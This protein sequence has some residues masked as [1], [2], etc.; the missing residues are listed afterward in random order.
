MIPKNFNRVLLDN[1]RQ[2]AD[3]PAMMSKERQSYRAITYGSLAEI[4]QAIALSLMKMGFRRGERVAVYARNSPHW[5][6]ADLGSLLAGFIT[7]AIYASALPDEAAYI[8]NDLEASIIFAEGASQ[9]ETLLNVRKDI[10]SV[11][12]VFVFD[13]SIEIDDPWVR[14]F[15]SLFSNGSPD[16]VGLRQLAHIADVTEGESP[17]CIIYTSGTTGRPKGVVLT[18]NNYV[19]TI[20]SIQK[21]IGNTDRLKRNLS[22]LPLAHAFERFAGHYLVLYMGRCIAYVEDFETIMQNFAETKPNF[23]VAV[24][25]FF[26]S[27]HERIME[28]VRTASP[29]KKVL[30]QWALTVGYEASHCQQNRITWS[31]KLRLQHKLADFLV[32]RKVRQ[33]FG[34]EIEFFVSGGAPLG[35]ELSEFFHAMGIL[36]LEGWGATEATTPSTLNKPDEF[37]FGSVGKPLPQVQVR[38]G[39]DG[40]LEVKGPNVFKEYWHDSEETAATFTPDGFYRTGD[41]GIIDE[42]GWVTI[43]DRKKQLIITSGGKNI[44]PAPIEMRLS[45]SRHVDMAYVHGDGRSYLTALLVLSRPAVNETAEQ[46]RIVTRQWEELVHHPQIAETVRTELDIINAEL[47][48]YMQIKDFRLL[49]EPFSIESGEMTHTMKLKRKVI[50]EKY[51]TL[52]DSMYE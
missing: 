2:Y 49:A 22:F 5:A 43:I 16:D 37:Q 9:L 26:E 47:P 28:G 50:R 14:P 42:D 24:P 44:A 40:E 10:P 39:S 21:H 11:R 12:Q 33:A 20:E 25:R 30:F 31:P 6:Q 19:K 52:I 38:V 3:E 45:G 29:V 34:G 51:K 27:V 13:D 8:I 17:M 35:K 23:V 4:C 48:R 46:L 36:I 41:I 32:Y 1:F 15:S 18:H 7:S